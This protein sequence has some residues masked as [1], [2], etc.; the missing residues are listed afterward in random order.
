M[1]LCVFHVE[2]CP[3]S[4]ARTKSKEVKEKVKQDDDERGSSKAGNESK[5]TESYALSSAPPKTKNNGT[6][7][8]LHALQIVGY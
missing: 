3:S 8:L 5:A 2:V 6:D 4:V 1:R 7:A